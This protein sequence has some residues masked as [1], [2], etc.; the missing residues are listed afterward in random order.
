MAFLL[1][2]LW[3]EKARNASGKARFKRYFASQNHMLMMIAKG[4]GVRQILNYT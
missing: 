1:P 4:G 2:S 3:H